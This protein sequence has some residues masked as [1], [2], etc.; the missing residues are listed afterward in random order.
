MLTAQRPWVG[1][2]R[3]A[4]ETAV[5]MDALLVVVVQGSLQVVVVA[6]LQ[7]DLP[8]Q[9]HFQEAVA[10]DLRQALLVNR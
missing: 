9:H 10:Q 1:A 5:V 2:E 3:A 4:Q 7:R 6:R 8:Q